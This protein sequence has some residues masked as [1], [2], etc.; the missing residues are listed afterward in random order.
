MLEARP[1]E[2]VHLE[3]L[4]NEPM[5]H[6]L[7]SWFKDGNAAM[8]IEN[9]DAF[10]FFVNGELVMSGGL[11]RLWTGR[12]YLWTVLSEKIK[13]HSI[14]VYRNLKR[15][16]NNQKVYN[17]IE[18]DIPLDLEIAHKRAKFLGFTLECALAK[19]FSPNGEPRS[20]YAWVR[21]T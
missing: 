17:R 7:E 12:A 8:L 5:N 18:M 10:S 1:A 13:Q 19:S 21:E 4:V 16:L 11:C 14:T 2:L 3:A 20:L 9:T 15:Y 6:G